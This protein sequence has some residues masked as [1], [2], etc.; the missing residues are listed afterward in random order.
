MVAMQHALGSTFGNVG[1]NVNGD[2]TSCEKQHQHMSTDTT[3]GWEMCRVRVT[4]MGKEN[5][6]CNLDELE[7]IKNKKAFCPPNEC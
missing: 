6:L 2:V 1:G 5:Q 7:K 3:N 4:Q